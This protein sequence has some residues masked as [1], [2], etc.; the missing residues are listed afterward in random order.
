MDIQHS[1]AGGTE[2]MIVRTDI[3]VKSVAPVRSRNLY[4]FS[5]IGQQVQISIDGSKTDVWKF[6]FDMHINSIRGG[7]FIR[8]C[9]IILDGF[10]L[11]AVFQSSQVTFSFQNNNSNRCYV[12]NIIHIC[13]FVNRK[14]NKFCYVEEISGLKYYIKVNK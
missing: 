1:L 13:V 7:M 8:R 14:S 2:K 3:S 4:C 5:E 11:S 6:L 10:S 12:Q 9:Q